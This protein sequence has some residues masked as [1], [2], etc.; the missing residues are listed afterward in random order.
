MVSKAI[1]VESKWDCSQSSGDGSSWWPCE[2]GHGMSVQKA[3]VVSIQC[4]CVVSGKENGQVVS[5]G[6]PAKTE[7]CGLGTP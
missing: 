4:P 7:R 5:M 6:C 1:S 3:P 2:E